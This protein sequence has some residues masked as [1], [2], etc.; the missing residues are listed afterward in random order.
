MSKT[1]YYVAVSLDGFLAREDGVVDWLSNYTKPLETP[2]DYEPFYQTVSAVVMGRKTYD[3]VLGFGK[4]PYQG[5]PGLV[6]SKDADF[7]VNESGV[8]SVSKNWKEKV[9][10]L[11]SS[12]NDRVWLVGGGETANLF[13]RENL[14]DEIIITIIPETIGVG[15]KWLGSTPLSEGWLLSEHYISKNGVIQLVYSKR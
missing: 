3:T 15:I 1:S 6:L 14:L 8:E 11:K 9:V 7:Q 4:Y 12:A 10:A 2:Y 5:K 13:V